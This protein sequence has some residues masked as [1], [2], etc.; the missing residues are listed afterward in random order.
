MQY[1]GWLL[2]YKMGGRALQSVVGNM[3]DSH[4]PAFAI[5]NIDWDLCQ[6]I[7]ISETNKTNLCI[8]NKLLG[9]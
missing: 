2:S 6:I 8:P 3:I 5:P 4:Q 7:V 9:K 1:V